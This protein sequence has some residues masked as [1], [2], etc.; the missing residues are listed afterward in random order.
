MTDRQVFVLI[1]GAWH[2]GWCWRWL[3][4]L[5]REQGHSVFTPTLSGLGDRAHQLAPDITL[6]THIDDVLGLLHYEDLTQVVLVGHSYG[7]MVVSGVV[8]RAQERI[9]RAIYLDAFLPSDG[10]AIRDIGVPGLDEIAAT[11]GDGWR[12][13]PATDAAGFGITDPVTAAWIDARLGDQ[14]YGTFTEPASVSH[15]A[16]DGIER[17]FILCSEFLFPA[18]AARARERGFDVREF[19]VGHNAMVTAPA[20]LADLLLNLAGINQVIHSPLAS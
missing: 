1:H 20:E 2:G 4:P 11:Y 18:H 9:S 10:E 7:G 12:I 15:S 6:T 5:L 17:S 14:P 13:P 8:E 16:D 19:R 3:A